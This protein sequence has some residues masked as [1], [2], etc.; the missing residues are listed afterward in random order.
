M[1][2]ARGPA[3][4]EP[5]GRVGPAEPRADDRETVVLPPVR[6]APAVPE[7]PAITDL[8]APGRPDVDAVVA[9]EAPPV[10]RRSRPS[11]RMRARA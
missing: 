7:V 10:R 2:P 11:R 1:T 6:P 8:A 9:P 3:G 5:I 4:R